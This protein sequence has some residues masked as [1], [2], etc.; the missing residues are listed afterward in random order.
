MRWCWTVV[1][2]GLA[3]CSG[4]PTNPTSG[5]PTVLTIDLRSGAWETISDP[6]PYPLATNATNQL[7]FD[8]PSSGAINY[9]FTTSPQLQI[10][11]NVIVRFS[12]VSTGP[13]VFNSLDPISGGCVIPTSVRPF[14]WAN[15]NGNGEYDRW[16]SNP[17]SAP[18]K[19]GTA[20]IG[21]PLSPEA[22]SSV[23]GKFGNA[24]A[25]TKYNFARAILN[26]SRLGVTFGGGCSFGH[27]VNVSGGQAQFVLTE[28]A[29]R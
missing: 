22:W 23:N 11:G 9:L 24:N 20:T 27:G 7:T 28:L 17:A 21:V 1:V 13:V 8:L 4:T 14:I 10:R 15:A 3:A 6:Q 29:I 25:E 16:W 26:V 19:D 18:L 5:M 12:I 2:A